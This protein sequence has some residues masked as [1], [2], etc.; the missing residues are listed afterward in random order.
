WLIADLNRDRTSESRMDGKRVVEVKSRQLIELPVW[1]D[2]VAFHRKQSLEAAPENL[3]TI[4]EETG[5]DLELL[6][7]RLG[8]AMGLSGGNANQCPQTILLRSATP[9]AVQSPFKHWGK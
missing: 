7:S 4:V 8:T 6:L 1:E 2:I 5:L 9:D 3:V